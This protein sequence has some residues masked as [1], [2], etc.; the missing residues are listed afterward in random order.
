MSYFAVYVMPE[1]TEPIDGDHVA[2]GNGWLNW[3]DHVLEDQDDYPE[4]AHLAEEGWVDWEGGTP[5]DLE[6]ELEQLTHLPD[7]DAGAVS[8]AL[9]AALRARPEGTVAL[10]V[11][12]G[13]PGGDD[14]DDEG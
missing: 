13:Q 3:G 1:G 7:R 6:H 10:L 14:D 12:D 2:T 9:L 5:D 8:A 4:S 11:S